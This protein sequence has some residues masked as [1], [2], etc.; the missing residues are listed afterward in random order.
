MKIFR[1]G[2]KLI[3]IPFIQARN[4]NI[5]ALN[6]FECSKFKTVEQSNRAIASTEWRSVI[7]SPQGVAIP[8]FEIATSLTLLA[9]TIKRRTTRDDNKKKDDPQ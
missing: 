2:V 3:D 1:Y 5:E 7:A 9:M 6:K 8:S 4:S